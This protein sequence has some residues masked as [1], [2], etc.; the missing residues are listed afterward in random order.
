MDQN[1]EKGDY[2]TIVMNATTSNGA[3]GT[4][5]KSTSASRD[6]SS[7]KIITIDEAVDII[8]FGK[9]QRQILFSA[10][11]CFM[12]DSMEIALLSFLSI[13]LKYEWDW[14][15]DDNNNEDTSKSIDTKLANIAS[16]MFLGSLMGA[17]ILGPLGD[18]IGRRPVLFI[19]AFC[20]S[21]FG[22]MTG[23][24]PK[25]AY[26]TLLSI[27]LMVGFGIGG[28]TVPFDILCEF[29]PTDARG[30]CLMEIEYFWTAG[31][32]LVPIV[33]YIS[34]EILDS[35]R[36]FVVIVAIPCL[37]SLLAGY[38]FVPE[39]PRWL[40]TKG[41][42]EEALEILKHAAA[43]NGK[44]PNIL[45][46]QGCII[47]LVRSGDSRGD[48]YGSFIEEESADYRILFT[49]KWRKITL[50][51]MVVWFVF[52]MG[53]YGTIM[54]ITRIFN[55]S[56]GGD[57]CND[58]EYYNND[59][60]VN[61]KVSFDYA[62]I[63]ISSSAEIFG[64][65]LVIL[66]IDRIGRV[67]TQI[68]AY[69][70]CG[71]SVFLL[72]IL[73]DYADRNMLVALAFIARIGGMAASSST[74][75]ATAEIFSTEIRSTGHSATS[76]ISRLGGFSIPYLVACGTSLHTIGTLMLVIH[77]LAAL[78]LSQ[79]PE[80]NGVDLGNVSARQNEERR[81]I[82]DYSDRASLTGET[83]LI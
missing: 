44:D 47:G 73:S 33:A 58:N 17:S 24:C 56:G 51:L 36:W 7:K 2:N 42:N 60:N 29:L 31:S 4:M 68:G 75:V 28:L 13:V 48:D 5:P 14:D 39:S 46:P 16:M 41:R 32:I 25:D 70:S 79:L 45:F 69:L 21:F 66:L 18:R 50:L 30:R 34:L 26:Y 27:R 71:I 10:G 49:S 81:T 63:L 19:A 61:A 53:Y 11:L 78:C 3:N 6:D 40:A 72:C 65:L 54:T 38:F 55:E 15:T 59:E 67:Y 12:A 43:V 20:I 8:G 35:W 22:F 76:A 23:L 64:T 83:E 80:T 52:A 1:Q 37:F 62:A 9:F 57:S 74:W 77:V 82:S